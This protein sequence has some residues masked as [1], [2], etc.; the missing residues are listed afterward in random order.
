ML[1]KERTQFICCCSV[2]DKKSALKISLILLPHLTTVIIANRLYRF[3]PTID[4]LMHTD[5]F[6]IGFSEPYVVIAGPQVSDRDLTDCGYTG[7][8]QRRHQKRADTFWR[9]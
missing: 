6:L 9:R 7:D 1:K 5:L 8:K 3:T 4:H 2:T